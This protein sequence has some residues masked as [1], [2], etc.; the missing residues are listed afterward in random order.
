MTILVVDIGLS[1]NLIVGIKFII[2]Y[3]C[4]TSELS[5]LHHKRAKD[6]TFGRSLGGQ[7]YTHI[8]TIAVIPLNVSPH[9]Q[10]L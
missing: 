8:A 2:G 9:Q 10:R 6:L 1:H 3:A 5:G 4:M 7:Y